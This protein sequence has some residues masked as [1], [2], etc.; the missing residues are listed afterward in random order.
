MDNTARVAFPLRLPRPL[1]RRLM[2]EAARQGISANAVVLLML[3]KHLPEYD[4]R[5]R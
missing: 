2:A 1:H 4:P 5:T 3:D